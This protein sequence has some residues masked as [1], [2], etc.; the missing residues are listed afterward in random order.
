MK[1]SVLTLIQKEKKKNNKGVWVD[2]SKSEKTVFCQV[3]SVTRAEFFEGG[4]N[5]LNPA[6]VFFVFSGDYEGEELCEYEGKPY[7][8]Y[9]V[10]QGEGDYL[11]L[12]AERK[13]GTNGKA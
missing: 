4:R 5:G 7:G 9:R 2:E 8:I 13:G 6:F 3:E 1:D 10:Y 11:E 12:Y